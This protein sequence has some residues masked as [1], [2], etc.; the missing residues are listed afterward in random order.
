MIRCTTS[1]PAPCSLLR[2][3]IISVRSALSCGSGVTLQ[4]FCIHS[5]PDAIYRA[6]CCYPASIDIVLPVSSNSSGLLGPVRKAFLHRAP[7][8]PANSSLGRQHHVMV[9]AQCLTP[10]AAHFLKGKYIQRAWVS[11]FNL[12][13][14]KK[15]GASLHFWNNTLMYCNAVWSS[16]HIPESCVFSC[17]HTFHN[18]LH[19]SWLNALMPV[20]PS[21]WSLFLSALISPFPSIASHSAGWRGLCPSIWELSVTHKLHPLTVDRIEKKAQ[22]FDG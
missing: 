8:V 1:C 12:S 21:G 14:S 11:I 5:L 16:K 10:T 9:F 17:T 3:V 4:H 2:H 22:T 6:S 18:H 13:A 7:Q 15:K 20:A 19:E